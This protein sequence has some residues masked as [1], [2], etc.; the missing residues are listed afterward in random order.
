MST[1]R[2]SL[3]VYGRLVCQ[4]LNRWNYFRCAPDEREIRLRS[5]STADRKQQQ[6]FDQVGIT[7][8]QAVELNF[9]CSA[10]WAMV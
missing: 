4:L 10:D 1:V 6:L 2:G 7:V 8:P 3:V 9:E 5:V